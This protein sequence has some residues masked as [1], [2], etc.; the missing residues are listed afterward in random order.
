M[1]NSVI[2]RDEIIVRLMALLEL[3]GVGPAAVNRLRSLVG[4]TEELINVIEH[5]AADGPHVNDPQLKRIRRLWTDVRLG[6]CRG[7]L[8]ETLDS[9]DHVVLADDDLYPV[10]LRGITTAPPLLYVRGSLEALRP[11]SLALVGSVA[12]T[13]RGVARARKMARLCAVNHIQVISGLARGIDGTVHAAALE[14]NTSTFAV[15]GHGLRYLFPPEHE[16]LAARIAK[17]GAVISQFP[18]DVRPARWTFPARNE[19]MCTIAKGTVIVEIERDEKFGSVIQ[20]RFSIK[21]G[22][23]VF[24]LH[25]NISELHSPVAMELVQS[26]DAVDVR[27]FNDVLTMLERSSAVFAKESDTDLFVSPSDEVLRS[28]V[29]VPRAILFDLDGVIHDCREITTRAYVET[30]K[31]LTQREVMIADLEPILGQSPRKV[32]MKFGV[33]A[34]RANSVYTRIYTRLLGETS[35]VFSPVVDFMRRAKKAGFKVGIVTNQPRSRAN[36]IL[37]RCGIAGE[38]DVSVTYNDVPRGKRKPDPLPIQQALQVLNVSVGCATYIG[39]SPDDLLAA[40]NARVRAVAVGW[41]MTP[42][43]ELMRFSPDLFAADFDELDV[44]LQS[45]HESVSH[46]LR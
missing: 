12:P 34:Q 6:Q 42:G 43:Q 27:D 21:H 36:H 19:L 5:G 44:L 39:D 8:A 9:G 33:D 32:F 29:D 3:Q 23:P 22:R 30:I 46:Q 17:T 20:A 18:P 40:R 25:S 37:E 13:D 16:E 1:A 35:C 15:V 24:I 14:S 31:T 4:S 10:N 38:L 28:Q 2:D 11:R 41:G 7:W 26:G 45:P